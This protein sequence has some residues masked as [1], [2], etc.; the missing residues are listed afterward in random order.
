MSD[1]DTV[2]ELLAVVGH[3]R[4]Q[5]RD[6][7]VRVRGAVKAAHAAGATPTDLARAAEV[8]RP[9]IYRWLRED[10]DMTVDLAEVLDDTLQRLATRVSSNTAN[11]LLKGIGFPDIDVKIR[12]Y[13]LGVANLNPADL[14]DELRAVL[15]LAS[16]T[17]DAAQYVHTKSGRWPQQ[18]T[19]R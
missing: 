5:E 4:Q 11:Q 13:R 15:M 19:L 9:T 7:E 18:V 3:L 12:R 6:I 14:D 8:T 2:P 16:Q 10:A 17:L 1:T